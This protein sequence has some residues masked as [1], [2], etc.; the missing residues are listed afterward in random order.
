MG[1]PIHACAI[2]PDHAHLIVGRHRLT[3]EK[4]CDQL[5]ARATMKLS[6]AGLHPFAD[7]PY[8]GGRLPTPWA[9][10]GWWVFIDDEQHLR[11]AIAYVEKNPM[12]SGLKPQH[13]SFVR[14][15]DWA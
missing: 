1:Y 10:K 3:I 12:K 5:K 15:V 14:P 6:K 4:T 9:R 7:Q 8:A 11:A 13:W 2:M